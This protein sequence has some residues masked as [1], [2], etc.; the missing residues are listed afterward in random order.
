MD[1]DEKSGNISCWRITGLSTRRKTTDENQVGYR[2]EYEERQLSKLTGD[3]QGRMCGGD[4]H[5][6]QNTNTNHGAAHTASR[7]SS[8][9]WPTLPLNNKKWTVE[10]RTLNC[11]ETKLYTF[12][13][14]RCPRFYLILHRDR[15]KRKI[16]NKKEDEESNTWI[17]VQLIGGNIAIT[18]LAGLLCGF[19][20]EVVVVE[21]DSQLL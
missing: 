15:E 6:N 1:A 8:E 12:H 20:E 5:W 18:I 21:I 9:W 19:L 14:F 13:W 2:T 16:E 3:R 17:V 7:R 4:M 11:F 10:T